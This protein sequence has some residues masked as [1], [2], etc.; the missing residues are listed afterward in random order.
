MRWLILLF[1]LWLGLVHPCAMAQDV[2]PPLH[3]TDAQAEPTGDSSSGTWVV[4]VAI[5][6]TTGVPTV[7]ATIM[8]EPVVQE[9]Q[10]FSEG[11][12]RG[13]FLVPP[14]RLLPIDIRVGTGP[15]TEDLII[16]HYGDQRHS[17]VVKDDGV[18]DM[19]ECYQCLDCLSAVGRPAQ[20][21]RT[22]GRVAGYRRG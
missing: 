5:W 3:G 6:S 11:E 4:E 2:P 10:P 15:R 16:L 13:R 9:L 1:S 8:G 17:W 19:N 18:I 7:T 21:P 22:P 20:T 14:G 12:Y